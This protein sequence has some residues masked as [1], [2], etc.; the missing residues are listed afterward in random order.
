[1]QY[2]QGQRFSSEQL[3]FLADL[4]SDTLASEPEKRISAAEVVQRFNLA[5]TMFLQPASKIADMHDGGDFSQ[6]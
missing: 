1:M 3:D 2:I 6:Q 5:S 4:L